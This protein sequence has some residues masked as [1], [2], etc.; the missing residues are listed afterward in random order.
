[1]GIQGCIDLKYKEIPF[2]VS[3][4]GAVI[5]MGFC[6]GEGRAFESILLACIPG[7]AALLFAKISNEMMGYGDGIL[8]VVMGIYLSWEK[9]VEVSMLAF[10]IAGVVALVLLVVFQKKGSFK[11]PFVPFL[12]LAYG[13]ECL[14]ELGGKG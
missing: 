12:G 7:I 14:I 4:A 10:V 1:L 11:I 9:L 6:I 13:L 8:F 2:V 5:G 3:L